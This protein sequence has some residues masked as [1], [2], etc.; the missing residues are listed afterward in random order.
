MNSIRAGILLIVLFS[1]I[2]FQ[3]QSALPFSVVDDNLFKYQIGEQWGK[4]IVTKELL[5]SETEIFRN[6]VQSTARFRHGTAFY[7]GKFND[8]H[9]MAT[10]SHVS[11]SDKC[12]G[13][14]A[15]FP[16]LENV[17]AFCAEII[18]RWT[19]I[20]ILIFEVEVDWPEDEEALSRVGMNF[21]YDEPPQMGRK[22]LTAGFGGA[23]NPHGKMTIGKDNDCIVFSDEIRFLRDPDEQAPNSH[24][25]WSFANGC[26]VSHGDSGSAMVDQDTGDVRGI[27]WTTKTPKDARVRDPSFL[28]EMIDHQDERIW[29]EISY[30]VP[31]IKIGERL[32]EVRDHSGTPEWKVVTINALLEGEK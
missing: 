18:G 20:D 9:L 7:L 11:S 14:V 16:F 26:D 23:G 28:K 17:W 30:A 10:N 12:F 13:E 3:G 15:A 22:L 27:I 25:V 4:T 24:R 32:K 6:A 5:N 29:S 31:A 1:F 2:P 21:S 8:R 19:D